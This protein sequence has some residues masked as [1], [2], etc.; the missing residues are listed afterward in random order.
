MKIQK[1]QLH[2][3]KNKRVPLHICL[4]TGL[5]A[6]TLPYNALGEPLEKTKP[7][8]Q[9]FILTAYYSPLPNQCCYVKGGE[10]I[11][12]VLN[13]QG[14]QASDGTPVYPGMIAAPSVYPFGTIVSLPGL[15][16]FQVHDRGGAINVLG[17][18]KHRLDV[19]MGHGEEGL[20][21]ALAFGVQSIKGTVYPNGTD[22]PEVSFDMKSIPAPI[23]E[24]QNYFIEKDNLL[25]LKPKAG[26]KGLSVYLLQDYLHKTGYMNAGATGFFGEETKKSW[27]DFLGDYQL[28]IVDSLDETS[29]AYLLGA[30]QRQGAKEPFSGYIDPKSSKDE[31]TQAQRILRFLGYYKGR[32]NGIYDENLFQ[33]I[34]SFQQ[35][36]MLVGTAEDNGA[37][38]IG[39]ITKKSIEQEWNR[40][41]VSL[42]ADRYLD[43][44]AIDEKL[45]EK[46]NRIQQFLGEDYN[47]GQVRLL[48]QALADLGFFDA[49]KIN[50]NFG[51]MTKEAVTQYQLD[52]GIITSRSDT[53]TGYVGPTTLQSLRKD[54]RNILYSVVRANG[55][56]AL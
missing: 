21:R 48:Q 51:S 35:D 37:G 42:H 3:K 30:N 15:G 29:A 52:R 45:E 56:N 49:Q 13:G 4:I 28:A 16:T 55:W 20:A 27:H 17:N 14:I 10:H 33:S 38:R 7:F 40:R 5:I 19:W 24:L 36:H 44:H 31:I 22:R 11:D 26:D 2:T 54:Q 46:G 41:I 8:T 12:K 6:I 32:T 47:G 18:G 9:E 1:R 53:G 34:L 25:A 43:L 39:P 50:G 23:Q